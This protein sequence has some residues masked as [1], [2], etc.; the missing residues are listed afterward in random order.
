MV[1]G[2]W[3]VLP[4]L[5]PPKNWRAPPPAGFVN[6]SGMRRHDEDPW[7]PVS[8]QRLAEWLSK[9]GTSVRVLTFCK[10]YNHH[11]NP[12]GSPRAEGA[13]IPQFRIVNYIFFAGWRGRWVVHV[14]S[15][16]HNPAATRSMNGVPRQSVETERARDG[17]ASS[18]RPA[19]IASVHKD[20]LD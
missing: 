3:E 4:K 8:G 20:Y 5:Y 7:R 10:W 18:P 1:L 9:R 6:A 16:E 11:N 15:C 19:P 12:R 2:C 17:A 14:D 13:K